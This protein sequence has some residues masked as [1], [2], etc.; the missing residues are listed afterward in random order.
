MSYIPTLATVTTT[1]TIPVKTDTIT[2]VN[3]TA[4]ISSTPLSTSTPGLYRVS[5]YLVDSTADL[6]AGT[7][8]L[9]VVYTDNGAG[10]T[11]QSATVL[12]T[13][14]GT[15]TQGVFILQVGSG[16]TSYSTS[17]T[18]AYGNSKYDLFFTMERL[19]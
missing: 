9:N 15:F 18:G 4:D 5:Y 3:Q 11:A 16:T 14:K 10:Q 12:L 17:H 2:L 6:A 1:G 13:I 7:V 8:R 19:N